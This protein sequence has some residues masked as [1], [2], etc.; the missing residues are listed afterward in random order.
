VRA[1]HPPPPYVFLT[2]FF[3]FGNLFA[4]APL[5]LL[6]GNPEPSRKKKPTRA[7]T[8]WNEE[9]AERF[10]EGVKAFGRDFQRLSNHIRSKTYEQ[11]QRQHS[12]T[13]LSPLFLT[14]LVVST[15][16]G[17]FDTFTI[18]LSRR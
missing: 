14:R 1:L 4:H 10:F 8:G 7:Y 18:A 2:A 13:S 12:L 11:V 17:R 15:S 16:Y 6:I 3:F 5:P 9:E